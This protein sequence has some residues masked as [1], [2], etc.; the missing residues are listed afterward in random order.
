MNRTIRRICLVICLIV[1][2]CSDAYSQARSQIFIGARPLGL[3][4]TFTAIADDGNAVYWNPAGLPTLKRIEFNSM[5]ANLYN[6]PFTLPVM[7]LTPSS[8]AARVN[9]I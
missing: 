2:L 1:V 6:I 7:C 5:Y 3:G 9:V 4:E 8:P